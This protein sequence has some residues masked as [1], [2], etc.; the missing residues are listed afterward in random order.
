MLYRL[1][2]EGR[3]EDAAAAQGSPPEQEIV[4]DVEIDDEIIKLSSI[5]YS[6]W[7]P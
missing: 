1:T 6:A 2:A 5:D 7:R 3:R 4:F